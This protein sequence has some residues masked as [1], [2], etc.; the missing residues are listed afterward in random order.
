VVVC[1]VGG[2]VVLVV[3]VDVIVSYNIMN[4]VSSWSFFPPV[5]P[6]QNLSFCM[7][8]TFKYRRFGDTADPME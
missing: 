7:L 2:V 6:R 4:G 8:L 3:V 5:F 1:A